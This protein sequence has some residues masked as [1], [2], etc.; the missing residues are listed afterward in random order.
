MPLTTY[1]AG[2][3]LT[4]SSLNANLSFAATNPV[5][6]LTL[7]KTQTIGTTVSSVT[8]TDAFSATYDAYKIMIS[9]GVGSAA[10]NN[11]IMTLG[12]SSTGYY[13]NLIYTSYGSST[14]TGFSESNVASWKGFG[15]IDT[16]ELNLNL[17]LV[18]PFLAKNS[19]FQSAT[20]RTGAA[21]TVNGIHQVATS[22][23]AFTFGPESGTITGGTVRVYG[24]QNS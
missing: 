18:N 3:V 22:F 5:G 8:V 12:A 20:A 16:T 14:A 21:G 6:G 19:T 15:S 23:T 10:N 13:W 7:I 4:A 24:Y 1:T 17:E 11:F 2:E 9:G